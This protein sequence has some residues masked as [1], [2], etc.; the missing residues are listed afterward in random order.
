MSAPPFDAAR[1]APRRACLQ[2][3]SALDTEPEPLFESI[4]ALASKLCGMPISMLA[5]IDAPGAIDRDPGGLDDSRRELL[6]ALS[7]IASQAL[8]MRRDL[9]D[10]TLA[11]RTE[12]EAAIAASEASHRALVELQ[13]E[14]V[15]LARADGELVYVNPAHARFFERTTAQATGSNL[16]DNI[17][18]ADRDAVAAILAKVLGTGESVSTENRVVASDGSQRWVAWTNSRLCM[19]GGEALLHSVGRDITEKKRADNELRANRSFLHRTGRVAGVGGWELDLLTQSVVWSEETLRLHEVEPGYV[20]T[21]EGAAMFYPAESRPVIIEALQ[22]ALMSAEPWDL[23]LPFITAK[24]RHGWV[25]AVGEVEFEQGVPVRMVGALLD[26]TERKALEQRLADSERFVRQITDNLAVRIAY[27]DRDRRYRFV[28]LARCAPFE[29]ERSA[30]LGRTLDELMTD[31]ADTVLASRIASALTGAPQHFEYDERVGGTTRRIAARMIPDLDATGAVRGVFSSGIDITERDAAEKALQSHAAIL[32]S[33]TEAI[34]A[35][36]AVVGADGRFR[37]VNGAFERWLGAKRE[38]VIGCTLAEVMGRGEYERSRPWIE[39]ALAGETVSYEKDYRDRQ[40][41]RHLGVSYIPLW[42]REGGVDGFVA[43]AQD[44][45]QHKQEAVRLLQLTQRDP[46]TGLLN[47][48]GF[49]EHLERRMQDPSAG[50]L[51]VLYIDLDHFKPV[52]DRHGHAV[53]DQLLQAFGRRLLGLVRPS[54]AVARL[55]GDEFA[56]VL[57][58]LRESANADRVAEKLVAAAHLPFEVGALRLHVG[59]SVGV[60]FGIDPEGGWRELVARADAMLY[61]AKASGRG[62]HASALDF[63]AGGAHG[64]GATRPAAITS[65]ID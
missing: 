34:P 30:V 23:E 21:L 50:S 26:I 65:S 46:L 57:S 29:R 53:G 2:T 62:R 35:I 11:V 49:K 15:S 22:R 20:P 18:A 47:R 61:R 1:E 7:G 39:R 64:H 10:R 12:Y 4:V 9:I 55:G 5:L 52:N 16:Y 36:V 24:G 41:A 17:D 59:A 31:P 32:R 19:P 8:A 25:H 54:D 40:G 51:A 63:A 48:T 14:F 60:A 42:L 13:A 58:G 28:N 43:V 3:L 38:S 37:L 45:T 27:V 33:V 6:Q 44:I 56:V